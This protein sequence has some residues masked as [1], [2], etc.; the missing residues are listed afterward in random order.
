M[1]GP[2]FYW[3]GKE[4]EEEILDVI[5]SKHLFRYGDEKDPNFRHKQLQA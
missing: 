3:I 2:G 5:R 1:P 4:E